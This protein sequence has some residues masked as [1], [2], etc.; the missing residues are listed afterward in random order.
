MSEWTV[1]IL[2]CADDTLYTG[3]TTDLAQRLEKHADGSGAK[4]TRGRGPFAVLYT[5]TCPT[6]GAALKRELEIKAL[7]RTEKL[8]LAMVLPS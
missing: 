4:Y 5:E 7:D 3:I 8:A 6:K 2:R 1:Y